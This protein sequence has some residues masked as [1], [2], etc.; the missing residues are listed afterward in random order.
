[1]IGAQPPLDRLGELWQTWEV[2]FVELEETHTSLAPLNFFRSPRPERSWITAA[3]T[4]LDAASL[5]A[6]TIDM[7]ADPRADLCLRAGYLALRHIAT[8]F[9]IPHDSDPRPDDPISISR[10]EFDGACS[11]LAEAGVPL[12]PNSDE[13]W[14]NFAGWRVNY[15]TVLLSLAGLTVAPLAEWISDRGPLQQP[16]ES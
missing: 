7:P 1:M 9:R 14:K 3:G 15:D 2:W 13:C 4:I 11:R 8:L 5:A 12:K 10:H 16:R 6:S